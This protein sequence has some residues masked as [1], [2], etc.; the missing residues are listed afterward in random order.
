MILTTAC[1]T[2]KESMAESFAPPPHEDPGI[3][4][5]LR[6]HPSVW[7][8]DYRKQIRL[9]E[10]FHKR[11]LRSILGIKWQDYVSIKEVF[12]RISLASMESILLQAQ[13]PWARHVSRMEDVRMPKAI[14]FSE[15]K[16][17]K[18]NRG[19]QRKRDKNQLNR[20]F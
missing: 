11:C 9:L 6:S 19:A 10:R 18:R 15:L 7:C 20:Q 16:E 5:S 12:E 3:Q 14:F 8:R 17:G 13:L 1:P 4:I 2:G